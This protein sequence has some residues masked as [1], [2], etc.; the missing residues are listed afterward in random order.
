MTEHSINMNMEEQAR[1]VINSVGVRNGF[2]ENSIETTV[3]RSLIA[4]EYEV[5]LSYGRK[6][7][8]I[9]L[10]R[11]LLDASSA[12]QAP[13][14]VEMLAN[15]VERLRDEIIRAWGD[16]GEIRR[17]V[18]GLVSG[19]GESMNQMSTRGLADWIPQENPFK[20][21]ERMEKDID[22]M[23]KDFRDWIVSLDDL[24]II[25]ELDGRIEELKISLSP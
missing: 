10:T 9:T 15:G 8:I 5:R 11:H 2:P 12:G 13:M 14:I 16:L 24:D 20:Q 22:D 7:V 21:K 17:E 4:D 1:Y 23:L 18:T 25:N 19:I 3:W 6:Y